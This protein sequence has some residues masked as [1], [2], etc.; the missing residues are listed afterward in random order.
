MQL[1]V[2]LVPTDFSPASE[3]AVRYAADVAEKMGG[4]LIIAHVENLFVASGERSTS[5]TTAVENAADRLK[6]ITPHNPNVRYKYRLVS[7]NPSEAIIKL[8]GDLEADLIVMGAH[9]RH[10]FN[11]FLLGSTAEE[12]IRAAPCPV[13]SL[14]G[15]NL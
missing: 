3:L 13:L 8:A 10:D 2:I 5:A 7:G 15:A 1:Q 14:K 12:V 11:R 4:T 9:G 6:K